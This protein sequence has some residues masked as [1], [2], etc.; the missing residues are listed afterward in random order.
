ML[1]SNFVYDKVGIPE[2]EK[3]VISFEG[4]L[5]EKFVSTGR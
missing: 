5:P 3:K 2:E 1:I 4:V